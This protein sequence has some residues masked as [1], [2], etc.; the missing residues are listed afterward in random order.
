MNFKLLFLFSIIHVSSSIVVNLRDGP[1]RGYTVKNG[2]LQAHVFKGIPF[3]RP[4][5]GNLRFQTPQPPSK[6]THVLDTTEYARPCMTNS[7]ITSTVQ[8]NTSEDCLYLNIWADARCLSEEPC[9]VVYLVH[10]GAFQGDSAIMF[11]ETHILKSFATDRFVFVTS[12]YRLGIFGFLDLGVETVDAPYNTAIYDIIAA[13]Q[14][15][16][17]E[18]QK[19]GGDLNQ[20]TIIGYSS[21]AVAVQFLMTSPMVD[22]NLFARAIMSSGCPKLHPSYSRSLSKALLNRTGCNK[23]SNPVDQLECLRSKPAKLLADESKSTYPLEWT[24]VGAQSDS[25]LLPSAS[26]VGLRSNWKPKPIILISTLKE[27]DEVEK[28]PIPHV[29]IHYLGSLGFYQPESLEA[30]ISHY[31]TVADPYEI[32]YRD[33]VHAMNVMISDWNNESYVGVFGMKNHDTHTGDLFYLLGFHRDR[34]PYTQDDEWMEQFYVNAIKR[35]LRGRAPTSDWLPATEKGGYEY[36]DYRTENGTKRQPHFISDQVF[37]RPAVKFWLQDLAEIDAKHS[38]TRLKRKGRRF[39][40]DYVEEPEIVL[41]K[42]EVND[43][44]TKFALWKP[45]QRPYNSL[46][47]FPTIEKV[48]HPFHN[49]FLVMLAGIASICSIF[50]LL[51][52][53]DALRTGAFR[54]RLFN[55]GAEMAEEAATSDDENTILL[56]SEYAR[57]GS[58]NSSQLQQYSLV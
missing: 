25:V 2:D 21:A 36:I 6:W 46:V 28:R 22:E 48:W 26:F 44:L 12:A 57:H 58:T 3:A 13:L 45:I 23:T 43:Q 19:F 20:I 11:N 52:A 1:I 51:M 7:T 39:K 42:R 31:S 54:R 18:I 47:M 10:G 27:M 15:T 41:Q 29:C 35:F 14:W 8:N 49:L 32:F 17:R 38:N 30:C 33:A 9:P 5:I 4:P 53:V 37:N 50:I 40:T 56:Q 24:I 16:K 55:D 34:S